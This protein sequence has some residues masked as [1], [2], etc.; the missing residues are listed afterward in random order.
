MSARNP[1]PKK[2]TPYTL[3]THHNTR[4]CGKPERL[5]GAKQAA[6]TGSLV[7][8]T[9]H[10]IFMIV[11]RMPFNLC[12]IVCHSFIRSACFDIGLATFLPSSSPFLLCPGED[13][14]LLSR[15]GFCYRKRPFVITCFF[16]R[17]VVLPQL[18]MNYIALVQ[19]ATMSPTMST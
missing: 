11:Y 2:S 13:I 9:N 4:H 17:R 15:C 3:E 10:M 7:V 6:A 14:F 19:R 18:E 16:F 12:I 1:T 8:N 5:E